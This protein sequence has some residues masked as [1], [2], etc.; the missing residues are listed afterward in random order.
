MEGQIVKNQFGQYSC[1]N[2]IY[3]KRFGYKKLRDTEVRDTNKLKEK[4]KNQ[5][6]AVCRC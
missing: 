4:W 2:M 1:L 6:D 5:G 3:E